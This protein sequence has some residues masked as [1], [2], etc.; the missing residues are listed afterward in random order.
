MKI[1]HLNI[2]ETIKNLLSQEDTDG[3]KKITSDDNGPKSFQLTDLETGHQETING[4]YHLSNLLQELILAKEDHKSTINIDL[5]LEAPITRFKRMIEDYYWDGL[6]RT[7]DKNGL[8]KVLTD[9][10]SD[11]DIQRIYVPNEDELAYT[12]YRGLQS[13]FP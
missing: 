7:I 4:T 1:F 6:T 9:E 5:I 13:E 12:Y 11:V 8:V 10:K 3:D 2:E